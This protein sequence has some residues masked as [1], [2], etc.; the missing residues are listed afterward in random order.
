M[1]NTKNAATRVHAVLI[2]SMEA[3]VLAIIDFSSADVSTFAAAAA[4]TA[5]PNKP[6]IE[7]IAN[8]TSPKPI[9][10]P[11]KTVA[12]SIHFSRVSCRTAVSKLN[13]VDFTFIVLFSLI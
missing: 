12:P 10:F 5:V 13:F 1:A 3:L 6:G 2:E 11:A 9:I 7:T 8:T 4:C